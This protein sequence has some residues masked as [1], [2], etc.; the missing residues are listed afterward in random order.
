MKLI[1][2][3]VSN[4]V[5]HPHFLL[6]FKML[7]IWQKAQFF[8]RNTKLTSQSQFS[9]CCSETDSA[10]MGSDCHR[11]GGSIAHPHLLLLH[12]Q[13]MLL[14]EEEEQERKEGQGRLQHEEHAGWRGMMPC[15]SHMVKSQGNRMFWWCLDSSFLQQ[16]IIQVFIFLLMSF[17]AIFIHL[18]MSLAN[19][20]W[21]F[22]SSFC[23]PGC[24][25]HK[26][27]SLPLHLFDVVVVVV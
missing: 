6:R 8:V 25:G 18:K 11:C 15:A 1:K 3:H 17:I 4:A 12:N 27:S 10:S 23:S 24:R 16:F 19:Q 21:S 7:F 26:E 20:I 5:V 13:E 9:L 2:S 14:Q 22:T